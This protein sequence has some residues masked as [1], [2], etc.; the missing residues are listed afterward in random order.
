MTEGK[1]RLSTAIVLY[2]LLMKHPQGLGKKKVLNY[3]FGGNQGQLFF[4]VGDN[5]IPIV[6]NGIEVMI[7]YYDPAELLS[8]WKD[9]DLLIIEGEGDDANIRLSQK[10]IT[11]LARSFEEM[12][13]NNLDALYEVARML[14]FGHREFIVIIRN[15]LEK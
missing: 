12:D 3:F 15:L 4:R 10:G 5:Q 7:Q 1:N 2:M 11:A 6:V 8:S 9:L 14:D 13:R